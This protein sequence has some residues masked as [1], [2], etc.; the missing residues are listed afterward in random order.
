MLTAIY[1]I[2]PPLFAAF[3]GLLKYKNVKT[4]YLYLFIFVVFATFTEIGLNLYLNLVAKETRPSLHF[5]IM[6]E[7]LLISIYYMY[8]LNPL[9]RKK[10]FWVVIALFEIYCVVNVVFVQGLLVYPNFVRATESLLLMIFAIIFYYKLMVEAN[11]K[12]LS[13]EPV[14]WFNT[15]LIIYFSTNFFFNILFNSILEMSRAFLYSI[16]KLYLLNNVFLYILI[17]IGF[18]KSKKNPE[19]KCHLKLI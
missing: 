7:F 11:I 12:K 17:A 8:Y 2:T 13:G 4:H 6:I 10:F 1:T 18:W 15:A 16:S 3:I 14:V 5:Y 19:V 9:V